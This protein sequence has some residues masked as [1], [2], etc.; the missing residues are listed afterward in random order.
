MLMYHQKGFCGAG[1]SIPAEVLYPNCSSCS[2]P[3]QTVRICPIP[4]PSGAT[5][6]AGPTGPSG[7]TGPTG[8]TGPSGATGPTGPTGPSGATGPTGPTGPSGAT[9]PTGPTGPSGATGPTGPTG[10]SGAT[11]PTGPAGT[12][13]PGAAVANVS[14]N[15]SLP[16]L[17]QSYNSLLASLRAAGVISSS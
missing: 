11:G 12:L 16:V 7:A 14:S 8:P 9:G 2:P 15:A 4:G 1:G 3:C 5:G 13:I 10:P 6:P 17:I